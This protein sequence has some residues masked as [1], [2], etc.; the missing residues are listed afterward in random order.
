VAESKASAEEKPAAK[1][2]DDE[3]TSVAETIEKAPGIEPGYE[4]ETPSTSV[5]STTEETPAEADKSS[6]PNA[7]DAKSE[8]PP[9]R[10]AKPDTPVAQTLTAGAGEHTPPDSEEFDK[11]GRPREVSEA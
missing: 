2:A 4:G 10:A 6:Y 11:E 7:Q 1:K 5:Q 3:S 9:V 8:D